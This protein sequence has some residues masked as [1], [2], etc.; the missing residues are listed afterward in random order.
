MNITVLTS[1][2]ADY[3]IYLPLLKKLQADPFFNLKIF[4]FGTHMSVFHGLTKNQIKED[5]F[6]ISRE[7]ESLIL[8]DS[9]EAIS[10][11]MG[12]TMLKFASVWAQEQNEVDLIFCLGDRYEMFGAVMASVPFNIPVAHIHGGETTIGAIDNIFRHALT[13]ASKLHFATTQHHAGRIKELTGQ[14]NNIYNVGSLSL[15][16]LNNIDFYSIGEFK[17]K[18]GV[19]MSI[20]TILVTYHPETVDLRNNLNSLNEVIAA[21]D[22]LDEQI[23]ITMPNADTQGNEVRTVLLRF[24]ARKKNVV[25]V[26]SLGTKG[27]F[28][29]MHYSKFLLGN[30]SSGIIE[31]ASFR[32]YVINIGDRQKGREAGRNVIHCAAQKDNILNVIRQINEL[33]DYD[34]FNI[35]GR[36]NAS[37]KIARILKEINLQN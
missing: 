30:S 31:A 14:E 15:D 27:Y 37:E 36:G 34:G 23:L 6:E 21:L 13:L 22:T 5:G 12:L 32:K 19:D 7:I 24:A 28:S 11:A 8:G 29:A 4:I 9:A 26:E 25:T 2:R 17:T 18:F 10:S 1:S 16:N 33:P 35:Y 3:G 20:P